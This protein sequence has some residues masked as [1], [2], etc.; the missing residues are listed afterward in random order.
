[1]VGVSLFSTS[2]NRAPRTAT[3]ASAARTTRTTSRYAPLTQHIATPLHRR[4]LQQS[5]FQTHILDIAH[6]FAL[7]REK[8]RAREGEEEDRE[9]EKQGKECGKE[10]IKEGKEFIKE[11][12]SEKTEDSDEVQI[13]SKPARRRGRVERIT[14]KEL[15]KPVEVS[16][17]VFVQSY[18]YAQPVCYSPYP[19]NY[20]LQTAKPQPV[21]IVIDE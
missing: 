15:Q 14:M 13:I 20:Y 21:W 16:Y 11:G 6:S 19:F 8:A 2:P 3:A 7:E 5:P 18:P 17:G 1:M 10:F 9:R 4:K 12:N